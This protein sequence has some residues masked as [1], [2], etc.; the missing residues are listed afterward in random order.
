MPDAFVVMQFGN[1]ELDTLYREVM[2][3]AIRA[4]GLEPKRVDKHNE[5]GLLKSEIIRFIQNSD[6]IVAD[7]TNERPNCYLEIGYAMGIDKLRNLVL[8]A[9]EDHNLDTPHRKPG[10]PKVHFDL[11]GY[12]ILFWK[13]EDLVSFRTALEARIRRRL[14]ILIPSGA[15]SVSAWDEDWLGQNR[16]IALAGLSSMGRTGFMEFEF[17][18]AM[19]KSHWPQ[20]QLV[21]AA[22][23]AQIQTFGWPIGAVLTNDRDRPRPTAAAIFAEIKG[24]DSYDYWT[25]RTNGDFFLLQSLFEDERV[26]NGITTNTRIVRVTEAVLYAARLHEQLGSDPSAKLHVRI[27]HGGL[28]GRTL[29][30][31]TPWPHPEPTQRKCTEPEV[32]SEV[33]ITR[34]QVVA[35]LPRIVKELTSALF[36]LFDFFEVHDAI[37]ERVVNAFVE[38][39]IT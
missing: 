4:A 16:G 3:P 27:R 35:N 14:A 29:Y 37:Y 1:P 7:L 25:L 18:Q 12:E 28:G 22:E 20:G 10:D 24:G 15:P 13:R 9:R 23:N 39:N 31:R 5:G 26:E 33:T 36:V 11:N 17:A 8:T 19:P 21:R 30:V 32:T 2:A 34:D 38:G 6:I